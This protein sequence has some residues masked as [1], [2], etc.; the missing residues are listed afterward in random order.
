MNWLGIFLLSYLIGSIPSAYIAGRLMRGIDIREIGDGN[1]GV[2]TVFRELGTKVG[3]LVVIADIR[4]GALVVV[5][6]RYLVGSET[7]VLLA[8]IMAVAGHNW[9]FYLQFRGGTGAATALGVLLILVPMA[10]VPLLFIASIPL[11][12]T[13]STKAFFAFMYSPLA[14]A[15]WYTGASVALI[16]YCVA[17]PVMV[18]ITNY[19]AMRRPAPELQGGVE[20]TGDL[21]T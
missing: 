17:L 19:L 8:G 6:A 18:G 16:G 1:S 5:L 7:A 4:K 20:G 3:I 14:L 11:L 13:R 9:P 15:A 10:A 12:A 2:A 21:R